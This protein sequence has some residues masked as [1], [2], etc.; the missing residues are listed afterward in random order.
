[1]Q[2]FIW[3][4]TSPVTGRY[5]PEGGLLIVAKDLDEAREAWSKHVDSTHDDPWGKIPDKTATDDKPDFTYP[6]S[7]DEDENV[8]V[9]PDSG[10]C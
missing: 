5:H 6:T 10:C 7:P 3:D 9:F 4:F 2:I 8:I 1:M